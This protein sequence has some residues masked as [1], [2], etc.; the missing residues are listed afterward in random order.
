MIVK[1]NVF[2]GFRL[3]LQEKKKKQEKGKDTW[4]PAGTVGSVTVKTVLVYSLDELVLFRKQDRE[5]T[6][7]KKKKNESKKKM[8]NGGKVMKDWSSEKGTAGVIRER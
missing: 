4:P 6:K 7:K 2:R 3:E 5:T 8:W 1:A